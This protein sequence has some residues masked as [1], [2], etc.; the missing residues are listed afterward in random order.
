MPIIWIGLGLLGLAALLSKAKAAEGGGEGGGGGGTGP[1]DTRKAQD[2]DDVARLNYV[3][4]T[5]LAIM[6]QD[7]R[8]QQATIDA[9]ANYM[10]YYGRPKT[11]EALKTRMHSS[12]PNTETWPWTKQGAWD[13]VNTHRSGAQA[14]A[15]AAGYAW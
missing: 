8:L 14:A 11:A 4:N 12:I 10:T 9:A 7:K 3:L 13:Y 6:R 15:K 1:V 2:K 5:F